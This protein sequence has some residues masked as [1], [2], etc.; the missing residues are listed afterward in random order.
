MPLW[1]LSKRTSPSDRSMV[2]V[3]DVAE[4]STRLYVTTYELPSEMPAPL[5]GRERIEGPKKGGILP[6]YV[7]CQ[8]RGGSDPGLSFQKG[9]QWAALTTC[10]LLGVV[11]RGGSTLRLVS[12]RLKTN[13]PPCQ[14]R[15]EI[16]VTLCSPCRVTR[17]W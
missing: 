6:D 9:W 7:F 3:L 16:S 15:R 5:I 8:A 10:P 2:M 12:G 11:P 4:H 17:H 14:G 1:V 13:R